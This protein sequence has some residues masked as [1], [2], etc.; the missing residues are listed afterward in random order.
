M[1]HRCR[2]AAKWTLWLDEIKSVQSLLEEIKAEEP[3]TDE[4]FPVSMLCSGTA[5]K[6]QQFSLIQSMLI[7]YQT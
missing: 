5:P 7:R 1:V 6:D 4:V 2:A 3:Q